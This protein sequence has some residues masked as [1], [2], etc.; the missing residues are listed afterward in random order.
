VLKQALKNATHA[1]CLVI[2]LPLAAIAGFGR[3]KPLYTICAH[4]CA[5]GP[6]LAGDYLRIAFYRLTLASCSMN[7]RIS[8]G[9]FFAHSQ[10]RVGSG[11]YIGSYCIFGRTNI[12]DGTQIASAVQILSGQHQHV[13]DNEGKISGAEDGQFKTVTIGANCWIGAAAVVMADVGT[14]TTI[15]AGS[16]VTAAIPEFCVAVGSPARVI[17]T[18][19]R[20]GALPR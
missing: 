5:L 14:G 9:S 12:G 6:G 4:L 20:E 2:A 7:S 8:F 15:G 11:V 18:L 10:A 3:I 13:R 1:V 16:V 17:K 19:E